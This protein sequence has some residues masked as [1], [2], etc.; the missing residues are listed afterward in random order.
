MIVTRL[1]ISLA[2]LAAAGLVIAAAPAPVVETD[3]AIYLKRLAETPAA[4]RDSY[5]PMEAVAGAMPFKPLPV[6]PSPSIP[7]AALDKAVAYAEFNHSKAFLIWKDGLIQTAH[8]GDGADAHSL[9]NANSMAK[10]VGAIAV[11]RAIRIGAIK[12][13]DQPASDFIGEWRGTPKAVITVRQLLNMTSGLAQQ[14]QVGDPASIMSRAYLHPRHDSIIVND[15]PLTAPP[16]TVYQYANA[17]AELIAVVIE[18]ATKRRY[19]EFVSREILQPIGAAGGEIWVDRPGGLAHAGCCILL[20]GESFL[21]LGLLLMDD[22][23][24]RGRRLLPEGYVQAMKTP[25]P[26]NPRYGL[27]LWIPGEYIQRRGFGRPDQ[28]LG[29]VLH[30]EPYLASDLF[31]F[32]GN[33]DQVLYMIP[34]RKLAIL[35]MGGAPAKSPEWD[36][37]YLPNLILRAIEPEPR[38]L[39]QGG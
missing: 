7:Q 30:S 15:Y 16:G 12:S 9:I 3:E 38:P 29:A 32:D 19:G 11:G 5:D 14:G 8:Y 26:Q 37:S 20:P 1:L 18:R 39:R 25:T 36:N 24:W 13:L 28:M 35:R 4:G 34:S 33:H 17:S 23:V 31:L 6:A 2:V 21:R 27:G 10:P 22:G